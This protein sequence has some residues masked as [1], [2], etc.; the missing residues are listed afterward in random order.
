MSG[1]ASAVS[2]RLVAKIVLVACAVL[3]ALY[4]VYLIREI[5]GLVLIAVFFALA[6]APAVNWLSDRKVPR[7]AAILMVYLG[8]GAGIFG[9][10]LLMVP[11]IVK[12]VD[13]LSNDLPG[14]VDDLRKN[15][16]FR[17]YDDKYDITDKH[18]SM[19]YVQHG[20]DI[21]TGA[22]NPTVVEKAF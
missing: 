8:I 14:Y 21:S 19:A 18:S 4:V 10:G 9:I 13:G 6:I 2:S 17:K 7:W 3:A 20:N 1:D 22:H 12:G 15:E 5:V 16:T 11:P